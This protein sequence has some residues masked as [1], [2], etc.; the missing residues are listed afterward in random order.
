[1]PWAAS[2]LR[3][4]TISSTVD[5]GVAVG[6]V[7]GRRD[8]GSNA[9]SPSSRYRAISLLTQPLETPWARATSS[10]TGRH[11]LCPALPLASPVVRELWR[12]MR[13]DAQ[14]HVAGL[15]RLVADYLGDRNGLRTI[16]RDDLRVRLRD[17]DV[18]VLGVRPEAEFAAGHIRGAVSIP[19]SRGPHC[20]VA[21]LR[22]EDGFPECAEARLPVTR[23][24]NAR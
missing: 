10:D 2:S 5:A 18:V 6:D 17:G 24:A 23:S 15:E 12:T 7:V 19:T 9:A 3:M 4:R 21:A 14:E 16:T 11:L 8:R 22:L 1:M 13:R 20:G